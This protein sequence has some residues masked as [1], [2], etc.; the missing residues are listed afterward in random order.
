MSR[1][2]FRSLELLC[3]GLA[4]AMILGCPAPPRV[5]PLYPGTLAQ[6]PTGLVPYAADGIRMALPAAWNQQAVI[7]ADSELKTQF[8]REGTSAV[9]QVYCQGTAVSRTLLQ[10][11]GLQLISQDT[12]ANERLW[13]DYSLGGG[14]FAPEFSAW[15]GVAKDGSMKNYYIAWKLSSDFGCTYCL[16]MSV[17]QEEA[18]KVEGEFIAIA[19]SMR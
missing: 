18:W 6:E 2:L 5:A 1:S 17:K 16:Y 8:K 12:V 19:R 9:L 15:T 7:S 3:S 14:N 10:V 11:K 4:L 13:P